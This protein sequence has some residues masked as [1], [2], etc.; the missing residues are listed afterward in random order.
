MQQWYKY[1]Q[2]F[3]DGRCYDN[4]LYCSALLYNNLLLCTVV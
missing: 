2:M 4:L 3:K 1:H